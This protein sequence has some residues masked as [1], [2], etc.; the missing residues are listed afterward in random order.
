MNAMLICERVIREAETGQ[1]SLIG[2]FESAASRDFPIVIPMMYVYAKMTDA[3]GEV[4]LQARAGYDFRLWANETMFL[5]SKAF[6][7][8]QQ[9]G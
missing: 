7:A 3:Q 4:S 8:E 6:L 1:V 5:D 2:L 9:S